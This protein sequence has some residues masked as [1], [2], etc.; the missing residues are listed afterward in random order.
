[1][2]KTQDLETSQTQLAQVL[3]AFT[4]ELQGIPGNHQ[5]VSELVNQII[6]A[7]ATSKRERVLVTVLG[8]VPYI[9]A[10]GGVDV[11]I[12]DFDNEPDAIIPSEYKSLPVLDDSYKNLKS[13]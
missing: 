13:G 4:V 12:V 1:M 3:D 9:Q 7:T 8:G 2:T 10:T 5:K 6:A 11:L